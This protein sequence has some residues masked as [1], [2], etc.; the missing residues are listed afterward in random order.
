[1]T[2]RVICHNDGSRNGHDR[3]RYSKI[4]KVHTYRI[5]DFFFF[6]DQSFFQQSLKNDRYVFLDQAADCAWNSSLTFTYACSRGGGGTA[7]PRGLLPGGGYCHTPGP[8]PGGVLPYP[9]ACSPGGYCHTPGPAP[10]GGTAIPRGLLLAPQLVHHR[11][12]IRKIREY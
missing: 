12:S 11:T 3:N 6:P 5:C 8:A 4:D 2:L 10:G 9:G 7:I 1:M